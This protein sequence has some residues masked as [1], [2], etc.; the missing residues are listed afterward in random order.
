MKKLFWFLAIVPLFGLVMS[1]N[2]SL[3]SSGDTAGGAAMDRAISGISWSPWYIQEPDGSTHT[4][5][6]GLSNTW[7][8]TD[9]SY[10][11]FADPNTGVTT[12]GSSHPRSELHESS[13][14]SS[15][16][17]NK[18][19]ATARVTKAGSAGITIGQV[20]CDSGAHTLAELQYTTGGFAVLY[21]EVKGSATTTSIGGKVGLNTAFTYSMAFSGGKLTIT[22]NGATYTHTPTSSGAAGT[23]YF[24]AG[25]YDQGATS[26]SVSSTIHSIVELSKLSVSHS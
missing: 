1:C 8:Y 17:T 20:F 14:W 7:F 11:A 26:G 21:E 13:D 6:S 4:G 9:G 2:N 10:Q 3:L 19:S 22:A 18:M 24:K 12:S 16:G 15:S 25:N 5:I 23:F